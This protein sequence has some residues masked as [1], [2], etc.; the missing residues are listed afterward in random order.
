M[1]GYKQTQ[2]HQP[3]KYRYNTINRFFLERWK[4]THRMKGTHTNNGKKVK[5]EKKMLKL[6]QPKINKSILREE[7]KSKN[8]DFRCG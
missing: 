1:N 3:I 2:T 4:L 8:K 5:T 7:T 6:K